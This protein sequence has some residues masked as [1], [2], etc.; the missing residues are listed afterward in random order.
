MSD[1][2]SMYRELKGD[3]QAVAEPLLDFACAQLKKRGAF[4]PIGAKLTRAGRTDLVAAAPD[5][6]DTTSDAVLP[7]LI[8][9]LNQS[10]AGSEAVAFCEWVKIE[11]E[12]CKLRDA[13][14]VHAQHRRG[15][16]VAFYLPAKKSLFRGWQFGE[17]LVRPAEPFISV[18]PNRDG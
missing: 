3:L 11:L 9:A 7:L 1:R 5:E 17:M 13:V 8:R 18:W 15:L 16:S 12:D 2:D 6:E 14:K 4:L 10:A